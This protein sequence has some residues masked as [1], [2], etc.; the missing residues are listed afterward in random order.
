MAA[1]PSDSDALAGFPVGYIGTDGVNAAGDF[2]P[3]NAWIL[4]AGPLAFLYGRIA[5]ANASRL[6]L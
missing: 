5:V 6:Q 4:D 2:V 3:R 1:V